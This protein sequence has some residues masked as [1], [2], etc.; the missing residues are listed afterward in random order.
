MWACSVRLRLGVVTAFVVMGS[1]GCRPS[2]VLSVPPPSGQA[3]SSSLQN[4]AGAE[5]AFNGAQAQLVGAVDGS[6]N[7]LELSG[8]LTDEFTFTGFDNYSNV[9]NINARI[10]A[11]IPGFD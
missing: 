9:A 2:D 4:R 5:S 10:T 6:F 8:L 11:Q 3:A 7:L 1:A